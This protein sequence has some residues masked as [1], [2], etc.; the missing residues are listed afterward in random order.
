MSAIPA[1][2]EENAPFTAEQKEYLQGF[3]AAVACR[4]FA[5]HLPGGLLTSDP[6]SGVPNAAEPANVFGTP[7][8]DLCEQEVWK[9]EENGLDCWDKLIAH[10]EENKLPDKRDTFLF[11]YHGLFYVGPA[12]ESFMLRL[13]T[14]GNELTSA[15]MRGLADIAQDWGGGYAHVTTR[16]NIQIREI[17]P[18]N[19]ISVLNKL[20]E[21]GLTARG[22][23]VDN[24]RNITCSATAGI[25]PTE[26]IDTR[27]MAKGLHYYILNNRDLYGLPRKFNISFEGGGAI[28]TATGTND[29]GFVA[30]RVGEGKAVESGVYFRVQLAGITG[31]EQFAKDTGYIVRPQ[32]SVAV[33]AAI[34]R[35]F[36]ENGDRT[37]RKKAR[38]KYLIDKWGT[39]RFMEEVEKKLAF[40]LQKLPPGDCTFPQPPLPHGHLG[41]YKQKQPQKNY[42]GVAMPVGTMTVRQMRRLADLAEHYGSGTLRLTV[43]Q[44]IVIPDVPDAFVETVKRSLVRM[45]YHHEATSIAGGLVACTGATG[46]KWAQSHTKEQGVELARYLEKK[47]HL[48]RPINI[49][50]TGCP[51][52]CA[53]HYIGDIGLLGAKV[54]R[55]G[56][57]VE[58]YHVVLGGSCVGGQTLGRQVFTGIPFSDIPAL[59]E[60]VLKTYLARRNP[61]EAFVEFTTRHSV[62]ELQE[63]FSA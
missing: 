59:L 33:A 14:P 56:E 27:P 18:K 42:I 50:L 15:Q 1:S 48:D 5:G 46:C 2:T 52:S 10:A 19:I 7:L 13:R 57:Q 3:F 24:L 16:S 40:P 55:H 49:H 28:A 12:Q 9:Y 35:V 23:G 29:I 22:S 6:A 26:L 62:K 34:V 8:E 30:V 58:G 47:V 43:W 36:N 54:T 32:D 39:D 60:G 53:Q 41:I 21:L 20:L 63:L 37:N 11:R 4:P 31:H 45:G 38:L 44:N 17:A 25:D 61:N 51:N